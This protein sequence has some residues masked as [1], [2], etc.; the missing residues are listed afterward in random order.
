MSPSTTRVLFGAGM[1]AGAGCS[2]LLGVE[3]DR[4]VAVKE[5]ASSV[6]RVD[7]NAADSGDV[8]LEAASAAIPAGPW[9]CLN[10]VNVSDPSSRVDVTVVVIN[11]EFTS[12]SAG[13]V[14]G[15]SDLDTV[16]ATWLP[17]VAVR[18]CALLDPQCTDGQDAA[19]TDEGGRAEFNLAGDF[20]GSFELRRD[21]LVPGALY[22]GSLVAG[23]S[24]VNFPAYGITPSVFEG[25]AELTDTHVDL[26][27]DAGVGHA[28]VTVYD[29]QDHQASGVSLSY[30]K[31]GP[32]SVPFYF[33]DGLPV[34]VPS[35]ITTDSYGL[36]G[37]VNVPVG[38]LMVSA[39]LAS[40][41]TPIGSIGLEIR[42]GSI[43]YAL[44]RVRSHSVSSG[45]ASIHAGTD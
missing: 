9:D 31:L 27:A 14:D 39:T 35:E 13:A 6:D 41:T 33:S 21:D 26:G 38:P 19:I 23:E 3:T 28:V 37:A 20:S 16:S 22:P 11:P 44:I 18:P 45:G 4:Y 2:T 42:P 40:S 8:Y 32:Q 17:G 7:A 43:S 24:A 1:L 34:P 29:C 36:G 30:E 12:T 10:D 25:L 5:D 15:G